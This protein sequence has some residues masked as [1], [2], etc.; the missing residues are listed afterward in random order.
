MVAYGM[1]WSP[2]SWFCLIICMTSRYIILTDMHEKCTFLLHRKHRLIPGFPRTDVSFAHLR[3]DFFFSKSFIHLNL[4]TRSDKCTIKFYFLLKK[5]NYAHVLTPNT[6]VVKLCL[7]LKK[8]KRRKNLNNYA[9]WG[10]CQSFEFQNMSFCQWGLK[11]LKSP[12]FW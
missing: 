11:E 10:L 12:K 2:K 5:L 6:R 8:N 4:I 7:V 3:P 9:L 1:A